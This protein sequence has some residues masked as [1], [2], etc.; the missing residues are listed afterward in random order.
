M[1]WQAHF[2]RAERAQKQLIWIAIICFPLAVWK[3]I[4]IIMWIIANISITHGVN[5]A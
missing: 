2:M 1:N 3:V 4:D 5:N